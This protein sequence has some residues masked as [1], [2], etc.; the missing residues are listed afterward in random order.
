MSKV[1]DIVENER[2]TTPTKVADAVNAD[3]AVNKGQLVT[4]TPLVGSNVEQVSGK[5]VD[6]TSVADT[7]PIRDADTAIASK[8]QCTA[9]VNFDGTTGTIRDSHNVS[10]VVRTAVGQYTINFM[11]PM[12]DANYT[13][14]GGTRNA[15]VSYGTL[16]IAFFKS[17]INV[18]EAPTTTSFKIHT[19]VQGATNDTDGD[20]IMIEVFG[21]KN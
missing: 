7:V 11:A 4:T 10:S 21:G 19:A 15:N 6:V 17:A 14:I 2:T 8:N 13:C 3:E 1:R 20:F 18:F 12:V 9:W 5:K 16:Q